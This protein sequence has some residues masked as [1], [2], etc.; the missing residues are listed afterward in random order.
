VPSQ[1]LPAFCEQ[2]TR[3]FGVPPPT[4]WSASILRSPD[5]SPSSTT[6]LA[7]EER[8]PNAIREFPRK[9]VDDEHATDQRRSAVLR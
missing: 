3:G 1:C 9:R 6:S 4:V 2:A 5:I 7:A 8:P